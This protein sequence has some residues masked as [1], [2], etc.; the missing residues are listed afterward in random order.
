MNPIDSFLFYTKLLTGLVI[1]LNI[2]TLLSVFLITR[3]LKHPE[4]ALDI[5][6]GV[7][8]MFGGGGKMPAY[9]TPTK[10]ILFTLLGGVFAVNCMAV[11]ANANLLRATDTLVMLFSS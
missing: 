4:K 1:L 11:L 5:V 9:R 6:S 3:W 2:S 10:V 7:G 8:T